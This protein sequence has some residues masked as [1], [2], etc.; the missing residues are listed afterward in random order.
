M[1]ITLLQKARRMQWVGLRAQ[2]QE[3]MRKTDSPFMKTDSAAVLIGLKLTAFEQAQPCFGTAPSQ[4]SPLAP[5]GLTKSCSMCYSGG[6]SWDGIP[7]WTKPHAHRR[8]RI[9]GGPFPG[10]GAVY[11]RAYLAILIILWAVHAKVER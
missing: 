2:G 7:L 6:Q 4:L 9:R 8:W 11:V 1:L 10:Q 5:S 3:R